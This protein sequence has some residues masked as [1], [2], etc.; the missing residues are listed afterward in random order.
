ML[1]SVR[2]D[3]DGWLLKQVGGIKNL[4]LHIFCMCRWLVFK[5]RIA[6]ELHLF[7]LIGMVSRTHTENPYNW[8]FL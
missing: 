3:D 5:I 7:R 2:P 8:I 4:C 1:M 6:V